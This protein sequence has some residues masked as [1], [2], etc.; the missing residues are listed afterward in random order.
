M[1]ESESTARANEANLPGVSTP[2][3]FINV[4]VETW[5]DPKN[6]N[7]VFTAV[8]SNH[9]SSFSSADTCCTCTT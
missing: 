9:S 3:A 6:G 2:E 5:D 8:S 7:I 4:K 1:S